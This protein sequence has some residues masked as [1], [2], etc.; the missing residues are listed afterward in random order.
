MHQELLGVA[1]S[2]NS[3]AGCL[4]LSTVSDMHFGIIVGSVMHPVQN[5]TS[6]DNNFTMDFSSKKDLLN[7]IK[8]RTLALQCI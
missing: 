1:T 8:Y 2:S 5:F 6:F 4:H 3:I 7:Y